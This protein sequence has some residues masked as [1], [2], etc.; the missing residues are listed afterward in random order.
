MTEHT[1]MRWVEADG[2]VAIT[3]PTKNIRLYFLLG[4]PDS[5]VGKESTCNAGDPSSV[6]RLGRSTGKEKGYPLQCSGLENSMDHTES[7]SGESQRIRHDWAT[8]T[9]TT[10]YYCI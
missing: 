2:L 6:P 7:D 8:F 9:F 5:S 10:S 4:F 1:C 3:K